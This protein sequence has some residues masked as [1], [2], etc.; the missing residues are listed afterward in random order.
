MTE[1]KPPQQQLPVR[2][3][4]SDP[5]PKGPHPGDGGDPPSP[6]GG[7]GGIRPGGPDQDK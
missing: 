4:E 7:G 3:K 6:P 5:K 1:K 2:P